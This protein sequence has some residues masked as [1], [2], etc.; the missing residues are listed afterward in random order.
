MRLL[1]NVILKLYTLVFS[2]LMIILT[3]ITLGWTEPLLFF[4]IVLQD[5]SQRWMWGLGG[6][7]LALIGLFSLF[8]I[9]KSHKPMKHTVIKSTQLGDIYISI[10][11]IEELVA[12]SAIKILGV[13]EIKPIIK[14][15]EQG[16]A[17]LIKGQVN[18]EESIPEISTQLQNTVRESLETIAGISVVEVKIQIEGIAKESRGRV[19]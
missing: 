13:R 17:V 16:I 6:A 11:A 3:L 1:E 4:Q 15:T 18:T 8:N 12:K 10:D 19:E 14:P 2:A 5:V 9:S 7:V